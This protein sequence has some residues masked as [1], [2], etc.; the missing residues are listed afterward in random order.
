[1]FS[2]KDTASNSVDSAGG[3]KGDIALDAGSFFQ[4]PSCRLLV[5]TRG[6]P[7]SY[8]WGYKLKLD[9]TYRGFKL[10]LPVCKAIYRGYDSIYNY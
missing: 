6:A 5:F 7:T 10:H 3:M 4:R 8:K 9:S 1:M 2:K